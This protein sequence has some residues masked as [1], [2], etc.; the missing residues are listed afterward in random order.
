MNYNLNE[1]VYSQVLPVEEICNNTF[2]YPHSGLWLIEDTLCINFQFCFLLLY[3]LT[4]FKL[5]ITVSKQ[6]TA[7]LPK[8]LQFRALPYMLNTSS[9]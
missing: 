7:V 3:S 4:L 1:Y 2:V 6:F 5:I 9:T 8:Q